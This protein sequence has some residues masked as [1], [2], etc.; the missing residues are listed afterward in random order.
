MKRLAFCI[1]SLSVVLATGCKGSSDTS[2]LDAK[3]AALEARIA[4]LESQL[5]TTQTEVTA[6]TATLGDAAAAISWADDVRQYVTVD[7]RGD[8][9]VAGANLRVQNAV[10]APE[11]M[12]GKGNLIIGFNE[13]RQQGTCVGGGRDGLACDPEAIDP[14]QG[15]AC[16]DPVVVTEKSG[17]HNLIVG[18]RHTYT[19]VFGI[20]TGSDNSAKGANSFVGGSYNSV[21]HDGGVVVGGSQ[22]T[23]IGDGTVVVGGTRNTARAGASLVLGG[24]G[25]ETALLATWSVMLGGNGNVV[26]ATDGIAP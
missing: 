12:N 11:Y 19:S 26:T 21:D 8:V 15:G 4:T 23:S 13:D 2:A 20:L 5:A 24:Q 7:S 22:N 6:A 16:T 3:V 10:D 9:V 14:C 25:N 18:P 1:L 17:S